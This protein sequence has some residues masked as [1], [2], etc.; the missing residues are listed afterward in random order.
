LVR[1]ASKENVVIMGD[2]NFPELKWNNISNLPDEHP[3]MTCLHDNFLEQLVSEPTRGS[4]FLDLILCSDLNF[5]KNVRVGEPFVTS[6]HQVIRFDLMVAK[7]EVRA[8]TESLN[9]FKADY[10]QIKQYFFGLNDF[11]IEDSNVEDLWSSTKSKLV[12]VRDKFVPKAKKNKN[13]CKWVTKSV[14][15]CR[16]AKKK[17]WNNYVK[18]GKNLQLYGIY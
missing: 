15:K 10:E 2:F 12:E 3:F 1:R 13:K 18:S 6:D 9:Y 16:E 8:N 4:N 7:E 5:V 11:K 14:V 17:A